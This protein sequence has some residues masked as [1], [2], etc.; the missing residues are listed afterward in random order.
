[1]ERLPTCQQASSP[2]PL[3]RCGDVTPS[4][5]D[6]GKLASE[7]AVTTIDAQPAT[8]SVVHAREESELV[9]LDNL[10]A[11]PKSASPNLVTVVED[12]AALSELPAADLGLTLA[13]HNNNNDGDGNS[14]DLVPTTPS[15]G[16]EDTKQAVGVGTPSSVTSLRCH[17]GWDVLSLDRFPNEILMQILGFL[18]VSDLLATSRVSSRATV[19]V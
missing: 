15:T 3:S 16:G 18:D 11:A 1:M 17:W 9:S 4:E 7:T 5:G 13:S 14:N 19:R 6:R 12:G 2:P 10:D 8:K